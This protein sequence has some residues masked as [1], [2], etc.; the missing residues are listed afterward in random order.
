M[1]SHGAACPVHR[2]C[3]RAS[4]SRQGLNAWVE[5]ALQGLRQDVDVAIREMAAWEAQ[6]LRQGCVW[7]STCD[8]SCDD[9]AP[10]S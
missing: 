3:A 10:T 9:G 2:R 4:L 8:G 5:R 1:R 6:V 7:A